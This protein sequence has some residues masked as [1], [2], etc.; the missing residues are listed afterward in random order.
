L[1]P[2]SFRGFSSFS[3]SALPVSSDE[4][5]FPGTQECF[6]VS[7]CHTLLLR[8]CAFFPDVFFFL[9]SSGI[10]PIPF[11]PL[12]LVVDRLSSSLY[13]VLRLVSALFPN[14]LLKQAIFPLSR[15]R[16]K[17][18]SDRRPRFPPCFIQLPDCTAA[19]LYRIPL[20][21]SRHSF[22]FL[23]RTGLS[24]SPLNFLL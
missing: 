10:S 20:P 4:R 19:P 11:L 3:H 13:Y 18:T 8:W 16:A 15:C 14:L 9:N 12:R 17:G 2:S 5:P 6:S 22:M 24:L 23:G 21:P 1:A 7:H